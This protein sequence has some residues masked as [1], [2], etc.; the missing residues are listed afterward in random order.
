MGQREYEKALP[1]FE[2]EYK[3]LQNFLDYSSS[4]V[5]EC[6]SNIDSCHLFLREFSY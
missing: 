2:E 1:V 5:E 6:S 4:E 3:F